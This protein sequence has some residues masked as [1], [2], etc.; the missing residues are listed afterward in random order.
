VHDAREIVPCNHQTRP[1]EWAC[2]RSGHVVWAGITYC[3]LFEESKCDPDKCPGFVV[4][5]TQARK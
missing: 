3:N 4:P 1:T 2:A 5:I